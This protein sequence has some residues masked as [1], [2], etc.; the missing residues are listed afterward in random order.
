VCA[1]ACVCLCV[2]YTHKQ[3]FENL[4]RVILG[5]C[6]SDEGAGHKFE[7]IKV[8]A[9]LQPIAS[10]FPSTLEIAN[11]LGHRLLR[12]C[13]LKIKK[14]K[15]KALVTLHSKCV[16][17]H[18]TLQSNFSLALSLSQRER[19]T[20]THTSERERKRDQRERARARERER[21]REI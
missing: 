20:H 9:L 17:L 16:P 2:V 8:S 4:C 19:E 12:I 6:W 5:G 1:C 15:V 21:E 18:H 7:E 13:N 11:I 3:T 14:Y 10:C